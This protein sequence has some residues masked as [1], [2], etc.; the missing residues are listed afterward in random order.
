MTGVATHI[1]QG[2]RRRLRDIESAEKRLECGR[3]P[4]VS[5][6]TFRLKTSP[7]DQ[8]SEK[9]RRHSAK[10]FEARQAEVLGR[11]GRR[12]TMGL[13]QDMTSSIANLFARKSKVAPSGGTAGP[14]SHN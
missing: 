14:A 10:R 3:Y 6:G 11:K 1:A 13:R 12:H 8:A 9:Y 7:Y 4:C 2:D 5:G